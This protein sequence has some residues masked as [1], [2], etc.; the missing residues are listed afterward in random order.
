M[1]E[2]SPVHMLCVINREVWCQM[3]AW[4]EEEGSPGVHGECLFLLALPPPSIHPAQNVTAGSAR[5][6]AER[7]RLDVSESVTLVPTH[8][9]GTRRREDRGR[10]GREE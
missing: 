4:G 6:R 3:S 7:A 2:M 8:L 1:Q 5:L 10:G 9:Q